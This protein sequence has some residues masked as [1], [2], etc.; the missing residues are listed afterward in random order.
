MSHIVYSATIWSAHSG[1]SITDNDEI[2]LESVTLP[3]G[4]WLILTSCRMRVSGNAAGVTVRVSTKPESPSS[5]AYANA[6]LPSGCSGMVYAIGL[7]TSDGSMPIVLK[8]QK[9]GSGT[10]AIDQRR[11][12]A[13]R[14]TPLTSPSW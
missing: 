3:A 9:S 5:I 2:A 7:Y 1:R 6:Y 14:V 11:N 8:Y 12:I 13:M 4:D 10:I